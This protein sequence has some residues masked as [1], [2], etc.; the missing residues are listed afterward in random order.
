MI[1]L[2]LSHRFARGTLCCVVGGLDAGHTG[3]QV[4]ARSKQCNQV[5]YCFEVADQ[6]ETDCSSV[7]FEN[8]EEL[9]P[10]GSLMTALARMVATNFGLA[11]QHMGSNEWILYLPISA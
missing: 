7:A 1:D 2:A 3:L 5:R 9:I 10:P 11:P 8:M 6:V 4:R